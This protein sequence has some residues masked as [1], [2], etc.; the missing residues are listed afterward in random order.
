MRPAP[1]H[2]LAGG[3]PRGS[4]SPKQLRQSGVA[5]PGMETPATPAARS[6]RATEELK[7]GLKS[8]VFPILLFNFLFKACCWTDAAI[9]IFKYFRIC[10][11]AQIFLKLIVRHPSFIKAQNSLQPCHTMFAHCPP[12]GSR[13]KTAFGKILPLWTVGWEKEEGIL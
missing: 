7:R 8:I 3:S 6:A 10:C 2:R 12:R 4:A 9:Q 13:V 11:W 5:S 1:Q